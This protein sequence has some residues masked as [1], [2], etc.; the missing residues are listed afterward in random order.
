MFKTTGKGFCVTFENGW[1][2]SVQ[3][4]AGNYCDN[5]Y[6]HDKPSN[7][8]GDVCESRTAEVAAWDAD[9][10]WLAFSKTEG[11]DCKGWMKP[12]DVLKFLSMVS[13]KRQAKP[14]G[15]GDG[16]SD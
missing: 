15:G 9:G 8:R 7:L 10:N 1:T 13:R 5:R 14:K 4:G 2:V 12:G 3:W 16:Q 11:D 6:G